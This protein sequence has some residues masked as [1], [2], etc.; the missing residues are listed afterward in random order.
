MNQQLP[1]RRS[2]IPAAGRVSAIT[3]LLI[4]LLFPATLSAQDVRDVALAYYQRAEEAYNGGNYQRALDNVLQAEAVLGKSSAALLYLKVKSRVALF[5]ANPVLTDTAVIN[6]TFKAFFTVTDK[7]ND[8]KRRYQEILNLKLDFHDWVKERASVMTAGLVRIKGGSFSMGSND[9]PDEEPVHAV[10]VSDFYLGR[11]EVTVAEFRKFIQATAYRTTA[12]QRGWSHVWTGSGWK[13]APG[14]TWEYD[15]KGVRRTPAQDNHPVI[16]VSWQDAVQY[17]Q[18]MSV[19]TG[20][21]YRLPTEAEWEYAARG[22]SEGSYHDGNMALAAWYKDNAGGNTQPVGQKPANELG[23]HD[24]PGNVWEWCSDWYDSEYYR[25]S[26]SGNPQGPE[27]G[28]YRV[29][30]GGSW[31]S[32]GSLCRV[33]TRG[34]RAA[35]SH[36]N[37]TGFRVAVTAE[38]LIE[39]PP[40]AEPE[41]VQEPVVPQKKGKK[42]QKSPPPPVEEEM[43]F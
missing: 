6:E 23:L 41:V 29:L 33:A 34:L 17:C 21:T 39:M 2:A 28:S 16:H 1:H 30:R 35:D 40:P 15:A 18:W 3:F 38:P 43:P 36:N 24:M 27:K 13:Q 26:P 9:N 8:P 14:V 5:K 22:G 25:Y 10:T 20:R 12:E 4:F 31:A 42:K 11:H 32:N 19:E 7:H 37:L